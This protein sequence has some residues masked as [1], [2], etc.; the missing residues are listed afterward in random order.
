VFGLLKNKLKSFIDGIVNKEEE[1]K[2]EAPAAPAVPTPARIPTE[3]AHAAPVEKRMKSV[4]EEIFEE[5]QREAERELP[6]AERVEEKVE[7][8]KFEPPQAEIEEPEKEVVERTPVEKETEKPYFEVKEE[9]KELKPK[10]GFLSRVK[11]LIS[12]DVRISEGDVKPFFQDLELALLESDVSFE[13][14]QFL[15]GDLQKRL[16]G[17][18]VAKN[19]LA[20]E[21][22]SEV[23]NALLDLF[24][25]EKIVLREAIA[26]KR[27]SKEPYIILF[28][29]PNGSGKTTTIAKIAM[30]LRDEGFSAVISASDSF[31]AAAIEQVVHHGEKLGVKVVK[32]SY[33]ADPT[34]VAFDAVAHAKA[35]NLDV[36]LVD[37]AGRQE[38]NFNL[39]KEMEK[40]NRV[41][42]PDLRV[43]VGEAIAGHALVEQVKTFKEKVGVDAIV[44]TKLDCD[45]KGGGV[46]SIAFESKLPVLFVG[47]GQE[48]SD[49]RDF[50]AEWLVDNVLAA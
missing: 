29:G 19:A 6:K 41:L 37:T 8:K 20:G 13:T 16:V 10:L 35:N 43:F 46:F 48:Y 49:L 44:L 25:S 12:S 4:E 15:L 26:R 1:K 33:G 21:V 40:M 27:A 34:A 36:V 32:H 7:E 30:R 23:R 50:N 38:T 5:A 18:R 14:T 22:Q 11:S 24:P 31:R 17:K 45:A 9:K 42:K 47:V 39:V 2:E 28:L 3:P